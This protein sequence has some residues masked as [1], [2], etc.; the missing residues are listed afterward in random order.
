MRNFSLSPPVGLESRDK[1]TISPAAAA[2]SFDPEPEKDLPPILTYSSA[3][4]REGGGYNYRE[5]KTISASLDFEDE[6]QQNGGARAP[7]TGTRIQLR[8]AIIA[9]QF[10]AQKVRK[11]P[12]NLFF[13]LRR[14]YVGNIDHFLRTKVHAR[15]CH[16]RVGGGRKKQRE[17]FSQL[18]VLLSAYSRDLG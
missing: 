5:L 7:P 10:F 1:K 4:G 6:E 16:L 12:E 13:R 17:F 18:R 15:N 9:S 8:A 14:V 2:A 11:L 3:V